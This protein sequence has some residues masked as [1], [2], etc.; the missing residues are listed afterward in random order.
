[1]ALLPVGSSRYELFDPTSGQR[2]RIDA[3]VSGTLDPFA[4]EFSPPSTFKPI[5]LID[6][7][8]MALA[9]ARGDIA[10]L[11]L[12]AFAG[13]LLGLALPIAISK[14]FS[15]IIPMA[16]PANIVPGLAALV[17]FTLA[18]SFFDL[19]R[20]MA[21]IRIEGRT[22]AA[23]Q[24]AVID[25]LLALPVPFFRAFSTGDLAM[26]AGAINSARNILSGAALTTLLEGAFSVLNLAL[27]LY[28]SWQLTLLALGTVLV[29]VVFTSA[30]AVASIRIERRRQEAGGVVA[31]LVFE[32]IGGIAKLRVAGAEARAFAVWMRRF[33][34]ERALAFRAG[35]YEN[36]V[37]VFN[38]VLPVASTLALLGTTG[39]LLA[40]GTTLNTGDFVAFNAAFGSFLA[41]GIQL[42]DTLIH[43]LQLVPLMERAKPIL[44]GKLESR[45]PPGPIPAS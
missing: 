4:F 30:F 25:R 19:T 33:R 6:L 34:E 35:V 5:R 1:M 37:A 29:S 27:L 38:D 14:V 18:S 40:N 17:A 2:V 16:V 28:Y 45:P 12:A 9:A 31:G 41:S 42:S 22:N 39:Y 3:H 26:R 13:G 10:R 8:K 7:G 36:F 21:L 43:S 23:L 32:M 11:L 44:E 24:A 15:D 20:A